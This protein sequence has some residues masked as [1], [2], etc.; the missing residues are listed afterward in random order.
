MIP[1]I[2]P[3]LPTE[4]KDALRYGVK[5]PL[6]Y[7]VVQL[8]QLERV[9][10]AWDQERVLPGYVSFFDQSGPGPSIGGY[11]P[12]RSP[13]EPILVHMLRT[14]CQPGLP[15]RDQQRAGHYDL[16]TTSFETFERNIRDQLARVLGA[17]RLRPGPRHRGHHRESLAPRLRLRIQPLMGPGLARGQAAMRHRA[18]AFWADHDRQFRCRGR[19]LHRSGDRSSLSGRTRAAIQG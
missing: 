1:Y 10:E 14:P 18:Q 12:S 8:A 19:R 15:A 17:W 9:S 3:D 11:K 7:T 4:Q 6:V 2:C 5:V 16:L 13:D